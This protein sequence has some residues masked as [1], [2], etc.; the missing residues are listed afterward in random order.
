[1]TGV[2]T[3]ALPICTPVF[4]VFCPDLSWYGTLNAAQLN[5]LYTNVACNTIVGGQLTTYALF[6]PR[7]VGEQPGQ[8]TPHYITDWRNLPNGIFIPAGQFRQAGIF[9]NV[10]GSPQS[11]TIPADDSPGSPAMN[12]PYIAFDEQGRLMG[13]STNIV[14]S[15]LEGSI[16]HPQDTNGIYLVPPAVPYSPDAIETSEPIQLN[17]IA[18]GIGYQVAGAPGSTIVY[19]AT[20]YSAGQSFVGVAGQTTYAVSA[21]TPRVVQNYGV[22]IEWITGRARA[23]KPE[24]P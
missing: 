3:C 12:L 24:S 22:R 20:S 19:N 10:L 13:R 4:I 7:I 18:P 23:V 11:A 14:L 15:V 6:S 5:M 16:M 9:H 8:N 1:M 21:G 17:G 2:Q